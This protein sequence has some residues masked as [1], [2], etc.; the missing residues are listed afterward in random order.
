MTFCP[1]GHNEG[2]P[3]MPYNT[4]GS[5]DS[6]DFYVGVRPMPDKV[7]R[8]DE[9]TAIDVIKTFR[10]IMN[11]KANG[12]ETRMQAALTLSH[13]TIDIYLGT[14]VEPRVTVKP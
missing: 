12:P 1:P 2:G 7:V 8:I 4:T 10:D 6:S 11:D 9:A 3:L 14:N 13:L 5:G